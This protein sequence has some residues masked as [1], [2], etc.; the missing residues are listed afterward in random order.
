MFFLRRIVE[1][2]LTLFRGY[3]KFGYIAFIKYPFSDP[4][5]N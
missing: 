1:N 3:I 4:S 2:P 5:E